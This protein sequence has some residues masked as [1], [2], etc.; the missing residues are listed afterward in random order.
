[1]AITILTNPSS[2]T[3]YRGQSP[4]RLYCYASV[5]SGDY[6]EYTWY[7]NGGTAGSGTSI[8]PSTSTVGTYTYYCSV[9]DQTNDET[10]RSSSA[11]ITVKATPSPSITSSALSDAT[12]LRGSSARS[13]SVSA[14]SASGTITYQWQESSN[15]SSWSNTGSTGSSFTPP[16][17]SVGTTYYRCIVRN[18]LAGYYVETTSGTARITVYEISAPTI[19]T[20]PE[21]ATYF[22]G[23]AA[24]ALSVTASA[25]GNLSYQWQRST[26]ENGTYTN[27]A[28]A[29]GR[30]YTPP[31]SAI[32]SAYYRCVVTS[33][34]NGYSKSSTSN[35]A[36]I[37]VFSPKLEITQNPESAKYF[38]DDPAIPLVCVADAG[39]AAIN[40]QWQ[41]K[42]ATDADFINIEGANSAQY[43]PQT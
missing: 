29:T 41:K 30:T 36:K 37:S 18:T 39:G 7:R 33:S 13:L 5:P 3:Y 10:A 23:E 20:N 32:G 8:L 4:S 17:S 24:K 25:T 11:T 43:T 6:L 38:V 16:T 34:A 31:T 19:T 21:D 40:Y 1:M 28:G 15:G 14:S 9:Y 26:D 22:I 12:Y 42:S 2:A 35:S 27:I